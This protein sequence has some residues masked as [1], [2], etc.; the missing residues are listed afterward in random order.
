MALSHFFGPVIIT[1]TINCSK[2]CW[3]NWSHKDVAMHF[4]SENEFSTP[5]VDRGVIETNVWVFILYQCLKAAV[6]VPKQTFV[7]LNV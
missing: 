7:L 1:V 4:I 6:L 5:V 3:N 2:L